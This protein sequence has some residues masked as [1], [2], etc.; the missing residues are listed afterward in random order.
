MFN[1]GGF[2]DYTALG[3]PLRTGDTNQVCSNYSIVGASAPSNVVIAG[4]STELHGGYGLA[5][6][7]QLR[8]SNWTIDHVTLTGGGS[9]DGI[10]LGSNNGVDGT[11]SNGIL[12]N[13]NLIWGGDEIVQ[14]NVDWNTPQHNVLLW[15]NYIGNGVDGHAGAILALHS[16]RNWTAIRNLV[17]DHYERGPIA[18]PDGLLWAN[19]L[20]VNPTR[21]PIQINQCGP[22]TSSNADANTRMNFIHNVVAGG[23]QGDWNN[24]IITVLNAGNCSNFSFFETG[25]RWRLSTGT[26]N[27]CDATNCVDSNASSSVVSTLRTGTNASGNIYPAGYVPETIPATQAGLTSFANQIATYIGARPTSRVPF[28]QTRI[29]YAVNAVDGSGTISSYVRTKTGSTGTPTIPQDSAIGGNGSAYGVIT[30]ANTSWVAANQCGGMP[31]GSAADTILSSG[32]TAL[33]EWVIGCFYDNVMPG[34]YREDKLQNYPAPGGGGS[35]SPPPPPPPQP[36]TPNPPEWG[37][38]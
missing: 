15:Q 4:R 17:N 10:D 20:D 24:G 29:D 8:Y 2:F 21:A 35:G 28:I 38:G 31:T 13:S 14:H 22:S 30:E 33:H 11:Y 1:V 18:S 27:N 16:T 12:M 6:V 19:N 7:L 34:G 5:A 3:Q 9:N 36:T 37:V 32:Y 23:A 25:N 26:I